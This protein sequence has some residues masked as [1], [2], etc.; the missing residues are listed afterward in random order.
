MY[1]SKENNH[2]A[3]KAKFTLKITFVTIFI[4]IIVFFFVI[5]LGNTIGLISNC[6]AE[7]HKSNHNYKAAEKVYLTSLALQQKIQPNNYYPIADTMDELA[8]FYNQQLMPAEEEKYLKMHYF[9]VKQH[10][11][12]SSHLS[13]IEKETLASLLGEIGMSCM[14]QEKYNEAESYFKQ[15]YLIRKEFRTPILYYLNI[16]RLKLIQNKLKEAEAF[17]FKIYKDFLYNPKTNLDED[18][19]GT[20][21]DSY[22]VSIFYQYQGN[23]KKAEEYA[24]KALNSGYSEHSLCYSRESSLLSNLAMIYKKQ[25][26]YKKA[27]ELFK[28]VIPMNPKSN[29]RYKIC[30]YYNLVSLYKEKG[31]DN[32]SEIYLNKA[33][34]VDNGVLGLQYINKNQAMDKLKLVCRRWF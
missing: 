8:D 15:A 6:L 20:Q 10:R 33:L 34:S 13:I 18:A 21:F 14:S 4:I 12:S 32:N 11:F 17:Y 3:G 27:E 26:K 16:A 31:D 23:Y 5:H 1:R 25:G 9:Y 30:N 7:H 19:C 2:K 22:R 29:N 28:K 24:N